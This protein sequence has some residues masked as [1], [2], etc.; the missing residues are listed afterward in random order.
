MQTTF[1][2]SSFNFKNHENILCVLCISYALLCTFFNTG[3]F[4][5]KNTCVKTVALILQQLKGDLFPS[6]EQSVPAVI[7]DMRKVRKNQ[8][9][10]NDDHSWHCR[11]TLLIISKVFREC[12]KEESHLSEMGLQNKQCEVKSTWSLAVDSIIV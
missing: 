8:V 9:K 5:S 1:G 11:K 10:G 12:F 6:P 7:A 3:I 4:L 2:F